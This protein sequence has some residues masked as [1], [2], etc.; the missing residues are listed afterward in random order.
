MLGGRGRPANNGRF[1]MIVLAWNAGV[2]LMGGGYWS[3]NLTLFA[4]GLGLLVSAFIALG[5][6]D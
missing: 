5:V 6:V 2:F 4:S 1:L 3:A